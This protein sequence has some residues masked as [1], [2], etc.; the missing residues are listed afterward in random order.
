MTPDALEC[1]A[2]GHVGYDVL[3]RIVK[4]DGDRQMRVRS[5]DDDVTYLV[6]VVFEAQPRCIDKY[7]CQER[8]DHGETA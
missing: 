2:C 6:P 4:V 8:A 3:T 1:G 5:G 7:A